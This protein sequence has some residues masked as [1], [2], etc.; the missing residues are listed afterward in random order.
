[1]N[2]CKLLEPGSRPLIANFSQSDLLA[3]RN[4]IAGGYSFKELGALLG[5]GASTL[6]R[7]NRVF[8]MYG[9]HAFPKG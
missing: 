8:E 5:R 9:L 2:T 3:L 4:G 7:Y 6:R 1:M